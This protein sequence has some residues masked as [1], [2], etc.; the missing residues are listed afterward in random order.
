[1][2]LLFPARIAAD[3]GQ[4]DSNRKW[5]AASTLDTRQTIRDHLSVNALLYSPQI[6]TIQQLRMM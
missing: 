1:V 2:I 3:A 5:Q 4:S 6:L